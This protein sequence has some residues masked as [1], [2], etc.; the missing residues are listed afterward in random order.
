IDAKLIIEIPVPVHVDSLGWFSPRQFSL[1][2][3]GEPTPNL[4]LTAD[5][6][7]Y[8]WG[9]L[10]DNGSSYPFLNMYSLD[11]EGPSGALVFPRPVNAGWQDNLAV[12]AG[13]ELRVGDALALRGGLGYRTA[14]V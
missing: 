2:A 10:G 13:G 5:V 9:E 11:P 12:R 6:T 1:G 14:A 7:Y 4:T 8:R 3:S